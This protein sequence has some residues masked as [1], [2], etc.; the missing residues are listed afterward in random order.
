MGSGGFLRVGRG[1]F[2]ACGANSVE[3][4]VETEKIQRL[5]KTFFAANWKMESRFS[6]LNSSKLVQFHVSKS[7]VLFCVKE[8]NKH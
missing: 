5:Q 8:L 2:F 6:T 3:E 1:R 4:E 7:V